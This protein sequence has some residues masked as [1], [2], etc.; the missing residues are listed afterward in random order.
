MTVHPKDSVKAVEP[1]DQAV[2]VLLKELKIGFEYGPQ[3]I[4]FPLWNS[5]HHK[6]AVTR[7]V[8]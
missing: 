8:E 4:E 6:T 2:R 1:A 7:I 5:F 3:L